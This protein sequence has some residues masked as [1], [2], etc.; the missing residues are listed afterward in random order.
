MV[1]LRE[2]KILPTFLLIIVS[3]FFSGTLGYDDHYRLPNYG[4]PLHYRLSFAKL[5]FEP[6]FTFSGNASILITI[7]EP[8]DKLLLHSKN[9][10]IKR[11]YFDARS[12]LT[13]SLCTKHEILTVNLGEE[14]PKSTTKR[15][16]IEYDGVFSDQMN[17]FYRSWYNL[18]NVTR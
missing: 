8:T 1:A 3:F 16:I 5:R 13:Y 17:G 14:L 12:N 2:S 11:I 15:L 6:E 18:G 9:L 10:N 4:K 7:L